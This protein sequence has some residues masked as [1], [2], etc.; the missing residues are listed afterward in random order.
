MN[1]TSLLL[2]AVLTGGA[3]ALAQ[4]NLPPAPEQRG[5]P[6]IQ[7]DSTTFNFGRVKSG[8][9]VK[10]SFVFTNSGTATLE[11]MDV[12]TGCGCT[13]AGAWDKKVE[14]GKTGIIPLQF[15]STGFGG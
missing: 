14:P 5:A 15:N 7:F 6:K 10:H 12:K 9:I 4:T 1:K 2:I 11:I 13:T 8:E 3:A